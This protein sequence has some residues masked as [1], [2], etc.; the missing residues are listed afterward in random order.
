M[1]GTFLN[2]QIY[3]R[4]KDHEKPTFPYWSYSTRWKAEQAWMRLVLYDLV[5]TDFH[6]TF[7]LI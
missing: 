7:V 1:P 6:L 5:L 2:G 3:G 4:P